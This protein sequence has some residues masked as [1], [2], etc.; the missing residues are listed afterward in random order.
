MTATRRADVVRRVAQVRER[1]AR[2]P[3]SGTGTLPFDIS[4]SMAAVEASREDVPFDTV[5]PLF[6]AGFGLQSGD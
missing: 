4:V 2:V 1:A 3:P 6:T 5:D